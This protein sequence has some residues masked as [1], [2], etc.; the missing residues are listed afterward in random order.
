MDDLLR[1]IV[2]LAIYIVVAGIG[3]YIYQAHS[4]NLKKKPELA[5]EMNK[6]RIAQKLPP[7]TVEDLRKVIRKRNIISSV[8]YSVVFS[9]FVS[10]GHFLVDLL[11]S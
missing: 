9:I 6:Q 10:V 7:L 1:I 3:W 5:E 11:L 4:T 2:R 8:I